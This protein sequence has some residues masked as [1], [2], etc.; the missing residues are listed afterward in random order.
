M[1]WVETASLSFV[2]RH[3]SDIAEEADAMLADLEEFRT[4]LEDLFDVVPGDVAVVVHPR[5]LMMNFA[6]PWLPLARAVSA[7][8]GRRYFAR[9]LRGERDPRAGPGGARE[10]GVRGSGLAGGADAR[11]TSRVRPRGGRGQQRN[12]AAAVLAGH[13][14]ALRA[15]GLAVR[16]RR[17]LSGRPG[18]ADAGRRGQQAARG[19]A[20]RSSRRRPA[21]RWCWAA[22]CSRCCTP[23]TGPRPAPSSPARPTPGAHAGRSRQAFGRPAASVE[24]EWADYLAALTAG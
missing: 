22:P 6:V 17:G 23:S 3:D 24:R 18:A 4:E 21:T 8:A 9:L 20:A 19:R 12:A 14:P 5:P 16:G 13:L 11:S 7:P 15:L 10:A 2:A 1:A